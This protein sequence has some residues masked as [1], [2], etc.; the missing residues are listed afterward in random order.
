MSAIQ[1][2]WY[3]LVSELRRA[4]YEQ[5]GVP[6]VEFIVKRDGSLGKIAIA[7]RSGEERL[8]STALNAVRSAAPFKPIPA[9][10]K[11]KSLGFRVHLGY[12]QPIPSEPC[13][14][15][16]PGV[17]RVHDGTTVPRAIYQPD[18]EYSEDARKAKYQGP[19]PFLAS[20]CAVTGC[21]TMFAF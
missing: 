15:A 13:P 20:P 12:N 5:Q 14:T 18:P 4:A 8:D 17:Y 1:T 6:I 16:L 2:R 21:P 11:S 9:D 19:A 3:S 7:E 10:F